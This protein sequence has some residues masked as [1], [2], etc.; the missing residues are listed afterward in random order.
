MTFDK[1]PPEIFPRSIIELIVIL[2]TRFEFC[3]FILNVIIEFS[4]RVDLY[5]AS[6]L[7]II[8]YTYF[9]YAS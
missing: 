5:F 8:V 1:S 2:P 3:N 6:Q 7:R 4:D 9:S